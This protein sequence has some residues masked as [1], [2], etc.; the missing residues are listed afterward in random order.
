MF[1]AYLLFGLENTS[2]QIIHI[3]VSASRHLN[4]NS[5][6]CVETDEISRADK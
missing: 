6:V 4:A 2:S 1:N 5:V 3:Q